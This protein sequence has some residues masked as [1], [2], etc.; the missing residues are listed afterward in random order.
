MRYILFTVLL[1]F[2]YSPANAQDHQTQSLEIQGHGRVIQTAI[3]DFSKTKLFRKDSVFIIEL[4]DTLYHVAYDTISKNNY[5][6]KR[7]R[8]YPNIIAVDILGWPYKHFLDTTIDLYNQKEIPSRFVE[9]NGK[10][11]I[12]RDKHYQL[13]GSTIKML[14]KYHLIGRGGHDDWYKFI[15]GTD[16]AKQGAQYY[17]CRSDLSVYK[18][19]ITSIAI[20][21]YDPPNITCKR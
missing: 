21:Y 5:K 19:K 2:A 6:S 1:S 7:G 12:W 18:K 13:T 11:F 8:A 10:L 20:G 17:F 9:Q 14:D 16:D 4:Y 15:P 3:R